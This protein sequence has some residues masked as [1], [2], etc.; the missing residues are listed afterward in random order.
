MHKLEKLILESYVELLNEMDGG[1]L[2]DYFKSKGYDVTERRPDGREA[3]FEGYMVSRGDGPYPQ[4]VIFQHNKDTDQFMI[5]RMGGYRIDQ[6]QAAKSGMRQAGY[7][8]IAGRDSYMT[9]GNYTPVD[10]SAE[11]LKDIVDHVMTGLDRESKA[12]GDFY[13]ARGRTS[14]TID[15]MAKSEMEDQAGSN[16]IQWEDLTDKQRAGIVKRYGKPMFN[17]QH[18]FFSSNMETYFKANSKNTETGSI[19]HSVIKLPSFGSLYRNFSDIIGDIKKLMGS[20]DIRTDQAAREFFELTKTNFRKLQRY[21]R[22][23]RPEQYNL[24]KMQRMMEGIQ[25]AFNKIEEGI[26]DHYD[27]VHVYDKDGKMFGTGSVEKVEGDKTFVRFDGSTVKRF[28]SDRVKPVKEALD[29]NDPVLMRARVA[30]MRADDMK[31]LDAYKKSP[32]GRAAARAQASAERKEE[33]ARELV[34]KLKIKRAQIMSDME[35]DP[36]IEPTGGPVADMYGDQLNKIDNAIEK[37]ASVYNKNMSYDQAVGKINEFVGKELEDRNQPLYDK[38]VPGQGDAETVEG[39]MLRAIN[40]IIYRYYNDGDEYFRGYGIE[41]AGPAHSFLVNANHPQRAAMKKIF[42]DGTDYEQTIKDALDVILDYIESRQGEYTKNTLGGIFDYEPEFEEE[43]D[44]DDD[45]YTYD[46]DDEEDDDY[47]QE[48]VIK[49]ETT[50]EEAPDMDAPEETVLED[51]T[52]SILGK[53]PTLK[54]AIINLQTDQFKEFVTTID[55]ISPRPSSFRVNLKN[56][57]SYILKWTGK[58]F[59]AQILGKR[60]FIDKIDD[61]QQALDKLARLYKEG[62][63]GGSGEAAAADTDTGG[64]GGGGGGDFPGTDAGGGGDDAAGDD[65]LG[66]DDAG[67]DDAGGGADLGGEPID[68]EEPGEDPE[69]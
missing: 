18:D 40:R 57:Q 42:G 69:A 13:R 11:G 19:G 28:P 23:E 21:L 38:L 53:F 61:Y 41:T 47:Y 24:L 43:D 9:D 3:G 37:A 67:A 33:K 22:T 49:E 14:G 1:R 29:V 8:G 58:G 45:D 20:D 65:A 63:M 30:K 4:S 36:E 2:F 39:E 16:V 54:K 25:K 44:Y 15:E 50:P 48:G 52:D 62:P 68:F 6:D 31:K 46:Y 17:G 60:Y 10:I 32:E 56:G 34:R 27:L 66:G 55:W 51:A 35:N 12:Q 64:S 5:S 59:E 7:S 26:N